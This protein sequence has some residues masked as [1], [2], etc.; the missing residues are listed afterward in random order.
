MIHHDTMKLPQPWLLRADLQEMQ[1]DEE[2]QDAW[3]GS[4]EIISIFG[5][6]KTRY[7]QMWKIKGRTAKIKGMRKNV[8]EIVQNCLAEETNR[9]NEPYRILLSSVLHHGHVKRAR[10]ISKT[11]KN[12]NISWA[13][14]RALLFFLL[15]LSQFRIS[16]PWCA[17]INV[18]RKAEKWDVSVWK[19]YL[20]ILFTN[21]YPTRTSCTIL[22]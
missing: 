9:W 4:V 21:F 11:L 2:M 13:F 15:W 12:L 5:S 20:K 18:T 7:M 1:P 6:R 17:S 19:M 14:S 10:S 3:R 22:A 8:N 16:A